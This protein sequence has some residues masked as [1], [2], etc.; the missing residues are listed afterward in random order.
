MQE[1]QRDVSLDREPLADSVRSGEFL[2]SCSMGSLFFQCSFDNVSDCMAV[3]LLVVGG[4]GSKLGF[5]RLK[6]VMTL[7]SA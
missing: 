5:A 2:R 6:F 4:W 1:T 3:W 7:Y